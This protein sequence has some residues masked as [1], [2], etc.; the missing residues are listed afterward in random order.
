[1]KPSDIRS[2]LLRQH[3]DLRT[4]I[5]VT[6]AVAERCLAG[7]DLREELRR[8]LTALTDAIRAHNSREEALMSKVF[9]ELD[10]WGPVRREVMVEEHILEHEKLVNALIE[11]NGDSDP[12]PA[13]K[14]ALELFDHM[15]AHMEREEKVFL[16]ADVLTDEEPPPDAFG[17]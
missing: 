2:E 6:R 9:P 17:G 7:E 14:V 13:A 10:A 11:T 16:G 12:R 5:R 1:M 4:R 3:D 15:A 8:L